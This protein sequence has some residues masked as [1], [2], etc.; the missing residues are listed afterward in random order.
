MNKWVELL[1]G[2]VLLVAMIWVAFGDVYEGMIWSA[3]WTVLIGCVF[4]I[5]TLIGIVFIL[6][7]ISDMKE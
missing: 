3:A 5:I 4:W 2:L 7:A 6:L 1:L